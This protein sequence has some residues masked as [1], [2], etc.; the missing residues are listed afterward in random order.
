M[1]FLA[2]LSITKRL[3]LGFGLLVFMLIVMGVLSLG[4]VSLIA[5]RSNEVTGDLMPKQ[6]RLAQMANEV[7]VIARA[8]RN[9]MILESA[10]ALQAQRAEIDNSKRLIQV[11]FTALDKVL[12]H[13]EMR[14]SF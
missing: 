5:S 11:E 13:P 2:Q 14:Q 10:Q 8:M 4:Q 1:Q 12:L 3:S 9:M 7:N 6:K